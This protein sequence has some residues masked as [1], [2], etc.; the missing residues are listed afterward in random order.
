MIG[1]GGAHSLRANALAILVGRASVPLLN[2]AILVAIAR[3][4]GPE[5]LGQYALLVTA[6]LVLDQ[7]RLLGLQTL[8]IR[9]V[10]RE[11]DPG[12][13]ARFHQGLRAVG[14]ATAVAAWPG[15]TL[16][17]GLSVAGALPAAIIGA[18][19][20]PSS[21][22]WA[23]DA[24]FIGRRQA[25]RSTAVVVVEALVR[26]LGSTGVLLVAGAD[27]TGLALVF[28]AGRCLAAWM[29]RRLR[30]DLVLPGHESRSWPIV[31][32][33][34]AEAPAFAGISVVPLLL[35]RLD[36]VVLGLL[37]TMEAL[38][39]Y[40]AATRVV[41][42][43]ILVP[44]SVLAANFA[45]MAHAHDDGVQSYWRQVGRSA[46]V[47][48]AGTIPA[49][50]VVSW[51]ADTIA[52]LVFGASFEAAGAYLSL[53]VWQVP[54]FGLARCVG[55]ALIVRGQQSR[56]ALA[57]LAC[58]GLGAPLM[59]A[60]T[61][62]AGAAGAAVGALTTAALMPGVSAATAWITVGSPFAPDSQA[63][64]ERPITS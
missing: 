3:L 8:A 11:R 34:L 5:P 19:F 52:T 64:R 1:L 35:L 38:G 46:A 40:S 36:L 60:L 15:L 13:A 33:M 26:C 30:R 14:L 63:L 45:Q 57:M 21:M 51:G 39:H 59:I 53:L 2:A 58:L 22:I 10:A 29:G 4:H 49:A 9:E 62:V 17:G 41:A 7:G 23:N 16:Y 24:L 28:L 56:V 32:S 20:W 43:L 25:V 50:L 61:W 6:F 54:L 18:A 42:V 48:A 31:R 44:D 55:D 47:V 12:R 37:G 27:L